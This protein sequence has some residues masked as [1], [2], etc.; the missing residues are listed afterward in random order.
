MPTDDL[1]WETTATTTAYDCP[2]FVIRR[3]ET[4]LP[5]GTETDYDYLHDGPA[6][7]VLGFTPDGDEVVLIEEWRQAVGRVNRALPAGSVEPGESLAAAARREFREET[8]YEP[9]TIEQ[10]ATYEPANGISDA[11]HHYFRATDCTPT[12]S[13]ALDDDETIRVDTEPYDDLVAAVRDDD[14]RDGRTA[15]GVLQHELA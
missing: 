1:A 6:V 14:I 3:D 9:A 7:V 10:Y 2:G 11:V 4:R 8:G 12:A 15:L 13:Q 5:D